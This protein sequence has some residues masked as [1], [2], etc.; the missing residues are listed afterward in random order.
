MTIFGMNI[1]HRLL[2]PVLLLAISSGFAQD[3]AEEAA[4][5]AKEEARKK[6]EK[7]RWEEVLESVRETNRDGVIRHLGVVI[8]EIARSSNLNM[9]QETKLKVGAKGAAE[10]AIEEWIA[11]LE[12]QDG[13]IQQ[14]EA[15][16]ANQIRAQKAKNKGDK[17][18]DGKE[19]KVNFDQIIAQWGRQLQPGTAETNPL[20]VATIDKTL[21]D[22]QKKS[23]EV[24]KA[25]R[26]EFN[27]SLQVAQMVQTADNTL[28]LTNDQ[29]QRLFELLDGFEPGKKSDGKVK[30][31]PNPVAIQGNGRVIIRQQIRA[32]GG[33]IRVG[34]GVVNS[35]KGAPNLQKL[36]REK[37]AEFLSEAQL[38]R[39]DDLIKQP[40]QGQ[41]GFWGGN[42]QNNGM[43][44]MIN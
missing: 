16:A 42:V 38:A 10:K 13:L 25:Q 11:N 44:I 21:T 30:V 26:T 9:V 35:P 22:D 31:N 27:R 37:L 14:L 6:D 15:M 7:K 28:R 18:D 12:R 5:K 39:W 34:N 24:T 23:W 33:V 40:K 17:D 29:R 36:D 8:S 3:G 32:A 20:W 4:E 1:F 2:L 43:Q 19:P 41:N